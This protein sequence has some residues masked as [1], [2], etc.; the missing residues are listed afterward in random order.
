MDINKSKRPVFLHLLQIRL[1]IS[2]VVSI[3]HRVTG[4]VLALG[5]PFFIY[6]LLR[7]LQSPSG[8]TEVLQR[9]QSPAG[10]VTFLLIFWVFSQHLFSGIRHL[11]LDLDMGM[12]QGMASASAWLVFI[13][14]IATTAGVGWCYL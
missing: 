6:L 9:L 10:K 3:T 7:S 12:S 1:P 4:I 8:F 5:L 13:A 11:L 14:A 2:G